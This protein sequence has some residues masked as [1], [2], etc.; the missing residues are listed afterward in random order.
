MITR[1]ILRIKKI[2]K[3]M[4]K[5]KKKRENQYKTKVML[6]LLR[7]NNG[8]SNLLSVSRGNIGYLRISLQSNIKTRTIKGGILIMTLLMVHLLQAIEPFKLTKILLK[9]MTIFERRQ[10][11]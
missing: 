5:K 10:L 9:I 1:I 3:I 11:K 8:W 4:K 6:T 7:I 2:I